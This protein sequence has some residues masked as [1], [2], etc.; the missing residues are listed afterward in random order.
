MQMELCIM[1]VMQYAYTAHLQINLHGNGRVGVKMFACPAVW[2]DSA[3]REQTSSTCVG[4][5]QLS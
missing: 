5:S 1:N 4:E 2:C 3:G